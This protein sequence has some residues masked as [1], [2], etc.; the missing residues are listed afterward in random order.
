M[1]LAQ[2]GM[3][4]QQGAS[5]QASPGAASEVQAAVAVLEQEAVQLEEQLI[6]QTVELGQ[7]KATKAVLEREAIE[8]E[9]K[10]SQMVSGV[11]AAV[12]AQSQGSLAT[13]SSTTDVPSTTGVTKSTEDVVESAGNVIKSAED[14]ISV[15]PAASGALTPP[16]VIRV[17][18]TKGESV[19]PIKTG[20]MTRFEKV[21]KAYAGEL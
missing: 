17:K 8:M 21:F 6:K 13:A 3:N 2:L 4:L 16:I 1:Q 11:T 7:T 15:R 5:S 20:M 10:I 14:V 19:V 12:I 18:D 9:E